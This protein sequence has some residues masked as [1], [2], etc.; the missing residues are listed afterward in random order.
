M[1]SD[2]PPP[3][4]V[5]PLLSHKQTFI[6]LHGR[7]SSASKF[8]PPLLSTS[9]PQVGTLANAFPYA[10]F[11]FPTAL[12]RRATIYKRS[13][14]NQWF[15]NWSLDAPTVREELQIDGLR[16]T[17]AYIHELLRQEIKI[18]GSAGNVVLGGLSQ[19]CAA[20]LISHLLWDGEPLAAAVG[21]CGWLP[22]RTNMEN[23]TRGVHDTE[24]EDE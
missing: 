6:L 3:L 16:E 19:G 15:D 13:I 9:I 2:Y 22:F 7:G 4:T 12:K 8:G 5:A 10:R 11:V 1:A 20:S 24:V 23:I 17:S 21:M 18:V 14:T